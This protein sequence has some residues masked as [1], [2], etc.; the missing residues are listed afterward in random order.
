[1]VFPTA[2]YVSNHIFNG[3]PSL[4]GVETKKPLMT[5]IEEGSELK[6]LENSLKNLA[7]IYPSIKPTIY[8][9]DYETGNYADINASEA[10]SAASIIKIPVLLQLFQPGL[11]RLL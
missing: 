4:R 1:M 7:S 5:P 6:G 3:E 8:V 10:Y 11:F 9:W 2:N